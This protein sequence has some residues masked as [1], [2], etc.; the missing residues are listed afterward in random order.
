MHRRNHSERRKT[1]NVR[2]VQLLRVLDPPPE[3]GPAPAGTRERALVNAQ[4]LAVRVVA[5]GVLFSLA[6]RNAG[7]YFGVDTASGKTLWVSPGR[8]AGNAAIQRAGN[9]IFSLEDDGELVVL[10]NSRSGFEPLRRYK[11]ADTDT[12]TQPAISGN[13]IFVKDVSS[14]TL[15]TLN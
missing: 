15:W 10:R 9:L 5:D 4:H 8:Q 14:L 2:G 1:R 7:Q 6:N 3:V 12:W 13:R 11:V